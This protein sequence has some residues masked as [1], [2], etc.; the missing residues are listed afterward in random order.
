MPSYYP[1]KK[2]SAIISVTWVGIGL[3]GCSNTSSGIFPD[4]GAGTGT[5]TASFVEVKWDGQWSG[6]RV[7]SIWEG[8]QEEWCSLRWGP[9]RRRWLLCSTPPTFTMPTLSFVSSDQD[10]PECPLSLSATICLRLFFSLA[11]LHFAQ[12]ILLFTYLHVIFLTF[13]LS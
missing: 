10:L 9:L 5:G 12:L 4:G 3:V 1:P 6:R 11:F 2:S 8:S 13:L 7:R